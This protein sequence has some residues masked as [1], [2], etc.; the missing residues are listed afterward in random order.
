MKRRSGIVF[1]IML[2]LCLSACGKKENG[3]GNPTS[4]PT[5]TP[6][7][8]ILTAPSTTPIIAPSQTKELPIYT[9]SGDFTELTAVTALVAAEKDITETVVAEAVVDALA[10]SAIYVKVNDVVKE[11]TVIIVDF[12]ASTP[13]VTKVSAS[14]EGLI[15]DAFGQ[16]ILDNIAE[17]SGVS[18]SVN[19]EAY[20]S[21][22]FELEEG[23]VYMRR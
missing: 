11:D 7:T 4:E 5:V 9:I 12:D 17:C 2:V 18:F 16:S 21:G 19:K 1:I 13:P 3:D 22:H 20:D 10:D 8:G 6:V 23:D 15:L 14:I